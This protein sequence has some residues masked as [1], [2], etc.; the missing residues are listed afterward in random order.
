VDTPGCFYGWGLFFVFIDMSTNLQ[1][2]PFGLIAI[3]P[4]LDFVCEKGFSPIEPGDT[5]YQNDAFVNPPSV[6][7]DGLLLTYSYVLDKR[8][9]TFFPLTRTIQFN[10]A[11]LE[12]GETVQIFL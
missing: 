3:Q 12:E 4:Y 8:Y 1:P 9:L 2:I 10:N 11:S 5:T 7:V 6:F